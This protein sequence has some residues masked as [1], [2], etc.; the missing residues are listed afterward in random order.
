[1]ATSA[2][3]LLWAFHSIHM[4]KLYTKP[5]FYTLMRALWPVTHRRVAARPGGGGPRRGGTRHIRAPRGGEGAGNVL[6]A[7]VEWELFR[8]AGADFFFVLRRLFLLQKWDYVGLQELVFARMQVFCIRT[9]AFYSFAKTGSKR[10]KTAEN[11][12]YIQ[13]TLLFQSLFIS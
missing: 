10:N 6:P 11:S 12:R 2:E 5:G 1:M 13:Q 8:I 4:I 9:F 3:I 7:K